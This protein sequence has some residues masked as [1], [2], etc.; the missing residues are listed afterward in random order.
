MAL[1][2]ADLVLASAGAL[3]VLTVGAWRATWSP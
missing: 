2:G 1:H 3:V